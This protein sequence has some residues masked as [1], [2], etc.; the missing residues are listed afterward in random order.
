MFTAR[1]ILKIDTLRAG[2]RPAKTQWHLKSS[3]WMILHYESERKERKS[4]T[5]DFSLSSALV[6]SVALVQ[7]QWQ[8]K[9]KTTGCG[10]VNHTQNL[11]AEKTDHLRELLHLFRWMKYQ[12]SGSTV[13]GF[14]VLDVRDLTPP[15]PFHSHYKAELS[16]L[17]S[18][19]VE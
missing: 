4:F 5:Q 2:F 13:F 12:K 14:W 8:N 17:G 16:L 15:P 7:G 18:I 6:T 19:W 1:S 3:A 9:L 11:N 10:C